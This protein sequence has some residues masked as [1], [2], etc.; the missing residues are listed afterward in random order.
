MWTQDAG[1]SSHNGQPHVHGLN[2]CDFIQ[3]RWVVYFHTIVLT[4]DTEAVLAVKS[5]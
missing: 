4:N 1:K 2:T 5:T 3:L